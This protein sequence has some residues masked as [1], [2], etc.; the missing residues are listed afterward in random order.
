MK[1]DITL[2]WLPFISRIKKGSGRHDGHY[3]FHF[4]SA[5]YLPAEGNSDK[6]RWAIFSI[7]S[8]TIVY[9]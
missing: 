8:A 1:L 2:H 9:I 6:M 5:V 7:L 4:I 3:L